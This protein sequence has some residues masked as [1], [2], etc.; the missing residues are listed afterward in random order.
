MGLNTGGDLTGYDPA[1]GSEAPLRSGRGTGLSWSG[2]V[3]IVDPSPT[4]SARN[5]QLTTLQAAVRL[6]VDGPLQHPPCAFW[7]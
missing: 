2:R 4:N 1:E 3:G 6:Y 5:Q 7:D